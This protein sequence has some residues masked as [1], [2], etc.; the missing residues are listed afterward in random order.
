[1]AP[2]R[3]WADKPLGGSARAGAQTQCASLLSLHCRGRDA[4]TERIGGF[5]LVSSPPRAAILRVYRLAA[6]AHR[7]QAQSEAGY[8]WP[9]LLRI[10][11][12]IGKCRQTG[13][14]GNLCHSS[15][16]RRVEMG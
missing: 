2:L 16:G 11:G 15:A 9:D 6:Q 5:E 7:T 8:S 4:N 13:V 1:M 12:Q 14:V 10:G 3:R